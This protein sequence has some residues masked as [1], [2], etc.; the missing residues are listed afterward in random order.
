MATESRP[1]ITQQRGTAVSRAQAQAG[2][3]LSR[4]VPMARDTRVWGHNPGRRPL[5]RSFPI[6]ALIFHFNQPFLQRK[7]LP[8]RGQCPPPKFCLLSGATLG[9]THPSTGSQSEQ[10]SPRVLICMYSHNLLTMLPALHFKNC[11][12][13]HYL[14]L[15][16]QWA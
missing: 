5:L 11:F 2:A 4:S 9:N 15:S 14:L 1:G 7:T 3:A 8:T 6:P 16:S 10:P 12:L 13:L